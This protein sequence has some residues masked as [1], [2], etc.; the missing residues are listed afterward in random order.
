MAR[1]IVLDASVVIAALARSDVHHPA[2]AAAIAAAEDDD[3]IVSATTRAEV[4]IGPLRRGGA[5]LQAARD[6]VDGLN[7]VPVTAATAD[8]AAEIRSTRRGI[9]LPDAIT[10]AIGDHLDADAVWTF[11]RKWRG[12]S[13]RVALL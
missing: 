3:L 1:L 12:V 10:L 2:A 4:L 9:S 5:V 11:D 13:K 6:F 7:T 8:A